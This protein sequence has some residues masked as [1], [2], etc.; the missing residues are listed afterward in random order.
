MRTSPH[1]YPKTRQDLADRLGIFL[2]LGLGARPGDGHV[3]A[4]AIPPEI[5]QALADEV[6][7]MPLDDVGLTDG[8]QILVDGWRRWGH[9]FL[10]SG[11]LVGAAARLFALRMPDR[12][13]GH[14]ALSPEALHL[15]LDLVA[16]LGI[17]GLRPV[18]PASTVLA[19]R[20]VLATRTVPELLGGPVPLEQPR[21]PGA[22]L[23]DMWSRTEMAGGAAAS[24]DAANVL[25]TYWRDDERLVLITDR[26][27]WEA[28]G[29]LVTAG[30]SFCGVAA[31][32]FEVAVALPGRRVQELSVG[33]L[34]LGLDLT[35]ILGLPCMRPVSSEAP[36]VLRQVLEQYREAIE[37]MGADD[38]PPRSSA[39]A[40]SHPIPAPL[41][42]EEA[43]WEETS[44]NL[45][46]TW[47]WKKTEISV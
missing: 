39:F 34:R 15:G 10:E 43:L 35:G 4:I 36:G 13:G 20:R 5:R 27:V 3:L 8:D 24:K 47:S 37:L 14:L 2:R 22:L 7:A 45:I 32:L 40:R 44:E 16:C 25:R 17:P 6:A 18:E 1:H 29:P 12:F 41:A 23:V 30:A 21:T 19:L 28:D 33:A 46:S 31:R 9:I 38:V 11:R 26:E 42:P